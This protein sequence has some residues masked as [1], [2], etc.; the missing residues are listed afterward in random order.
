MYKKFIRKSGKKSTNYEKSAKDARQVFPQLSKRQLPDSIN[1]ATP[2]DL[3]Y[4]F[5]EY[6][7]GP[8]LFDRASY[9]FASPKST[10][11]DKWI[12]TGLGVLITAG[13]IGGLLNATRHG[14]SNEANFD[15]G[16]YDP[17]K[18]YL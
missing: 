1:E 4:L 7:K 9:P 6:K 10:D 8:L 13:G 12:A 15:T 11:W 2:G 18:Q 16:Q 17:S 3:N 5:N 14:R